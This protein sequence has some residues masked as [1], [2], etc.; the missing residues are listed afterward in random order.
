MQETQSYAESIYESALFGKPTSLAELQLLCL[1][2]I[3]GNFQNK[4]F[5]FGAVKSLALAK[6]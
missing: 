5:F 3:N 2:T 4:K 1:S 6:T